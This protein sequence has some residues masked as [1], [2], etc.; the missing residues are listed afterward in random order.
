[1]HTGRHARAVRNVRRSDGQQPTRTPRV[2]RH[3]SEG[4]CRR[5]ASSTWSTRR[6][7]TIAFPGPSAYWPTS[8]ARSWSSSSPPNAA[9]ADQ[10]RRILSMSLRRATTRPCSCSDIDSSSRCEPLR[11]CSDGPSTSSNTDRV[12]VR[13]IDSAIGSGGGRGTF[14]PCEG[15][16]SGIVATNRRRAS[17][18]PVSTAS[19][20]VPRTAIGYRCTG[21]GGGRHPRLGG[22]D[23]TRSRGDRW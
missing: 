18:E 20:I 3:R 15:S 19:P 21:I 4:G 10:P 22:R 9:D 17:S 2:R 8:A 12:G 7:S 16:G 14:A 6:C 1:M 13:R 5:A 11:A 23:R